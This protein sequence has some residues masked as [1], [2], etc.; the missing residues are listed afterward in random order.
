MTPLHNSENRT[1]IIKIWRK[2][3]KRFQRAKFKQESSQTAPAEDAEHV[4]L[5]TVIRSGKLL[6]KAVRG[7]NGMEWQ[8]VGKK[9]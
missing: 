6:W 9:N 2:L 5:N 3:V 4:P 7:R 1:R 8:V